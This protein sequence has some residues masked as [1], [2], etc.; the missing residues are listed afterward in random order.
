MKLKRKLKDFS[1]QT[2]ID[3]LYIDRVK[4]LVDEEMYK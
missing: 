2:T 3:N 1:H 4:G